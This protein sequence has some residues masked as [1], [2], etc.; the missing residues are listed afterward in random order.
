M[1]TED[2]KMEERADTK[3]KMQ[4]QTVDKTCYIRQKRAL[5]R[6]KAAD[7]DNLTVYIYGVTGVGKT[8]LYRQYLKNRR[9]ILLNAGTMT[10]Q[11]VQIEETQRRK[12]VVIDNLHELALQEEDE[13]LRQAIIA[14]IR[15]PDVWLLL[16]GRCAVPPWL[17]AARYR[18]VFYIIDQQQ[19]LFDEEMAQQYVEATGIVFTPSQMA[20][21][22]VNTTGVAIAWRI[23]KDVYDK[24]LEEEGGGPEITD[25]Q[26]DQLTEETK[27]QMW[28][29]LE[30][31]VYDQWDMVIQEFLMEMSIVD[32]FTIQLAEMVT[33]RTDVEPLLERVKGAGNF[34]DVELTGSE[35][36]FRVRKELQISM[37]R[38]LRRKF[39]REK[40]RSLYENAG[41]YY[42]L[43]RELLKALHM[44]ETVGDTER[45][46]SILTENARNAPNNGYFY[47][48]KKYYLALPEEIVRRSPELMCGMSML[49]SLLLNVDES[50]RWYGELE[51][52][53]RT[54]TGSE[55]KAARSRLVYLD[56]GLPHRSSDELIGVIKHAYTLLTDRQIRLQEF[57]VT[58]NQASQMNGGKDFCLWSCR[59][60]ELAG[61]IGKLLE[62]LLGK[63]GKGLV[64]LALAES[65]L[66]KGEDSYEIATL[67]NR[68]RM[69]AEAGGKIEQ[70]FVGDG[71]LAWLHIL[72][73]RVGEA[74]ELLQRFYQKAEQEGADRLL[75]NIETFLI[76][77][78]LYSGDTDKAERWMKTA[79]D[80]E[81]G[82]NIYDRFHYMTKI[83][84]WL[85]E[86]KYERA[87]M[88]LDRMAYYAAV[89]KRTY[90]SMETE[91]LRAIAQYR[92]GNS[93]WDETFSCV[94]SRI[95]IYGFVRI[96]SREG[97]AVLPLLQ[98]T[99]WQP[100]KD[101][102]RE[103]E[104]KNRLFWKQVQEETKR[105]AGFY[106]QYLADGR[107][108]VILSRTM[109]DILKLMAE[110]LS[111]EK[112]AVQLHMSVAN[113]KYHTQQ[114]YRKLQVSGKAEAVREAGKRGYL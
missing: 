4:P 52:Y 44:Y 48:L 43:N 107:Q 86:G 27:S 45:I 5:K 75:P 33:G 102:D 100:S 94:L 57:S 103:T 28:D 85:Q 71:I 78:A 11:E 79:P 90:I 19:L 82:F 41:L 36:V 108:E 106:P 10:L 66:E 17:T 46:A 95:E 91:I 22:N 9:Y 114:M 49:Q 98:K 21:A 81:L 38:R 23:V 60:R 40:I 77:C 39:S 87:L 84:I 93:A 109:L 105:V 58:S 16:V 51:N 8:E 50:E 13:Q 83:R 56:I 110:G 92:C 61:S 89:M 80:E 67:A 35:T 26:F 29:Y 3:K 101:A 34:M 32:E 112:I 96:I 64:N 12:T 68:G 2:G 113:V 111:K 15:R 55:K 88:L 97:A 59:D 7:A 74:A 53:V 47:E 69:Q 31:H 24:I 76:R 54:H 99:S 70:C 73:G 1:Y 14:L 65:F 6:L 62:V 37:Q 18:E 72:Y 42:Q 25:Q 104:K 30:Y 20:Q 63:Y